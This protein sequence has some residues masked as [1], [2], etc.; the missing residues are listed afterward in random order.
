MFSNI[1]A[2]K[3]SKSR[4][5]FLSG[6]YLLQKL[7][8]IQNSF[9]NC[10]SQK[11]SKILET[12][13]LLD[14]RLSILLKQNFYHF[15]VTSTSTTYTIYWTIYES[16]FKSKTILDVCSLFSWYK[17]SSQITWTWRKFIHQIFLTVSIS[18][19]SKNVRNYNRCSASVKTQ[20]INDD[21]DVSKDSNFYV[22][23]QKKKG[24]P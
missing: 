20:Y 6:L 3:N 16:K 9:V 17:G 22:H 24:E 11:E 7:Y 12:Q 4:E 15:R 23:D 13:Q 18:S 2:L 14:R 8:Q 1:G 10:C 5:K 19:W 21:R